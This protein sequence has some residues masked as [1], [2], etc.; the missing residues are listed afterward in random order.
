MPDLTADLE[1]FEHSSVAQGIWFHT[2]KV[3]EFGD[4][5]VI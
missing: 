4:T 2:L 5:S 1:F 3:E